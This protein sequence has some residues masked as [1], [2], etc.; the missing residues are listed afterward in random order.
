MALAKILEDNGVIV[1]YNSKNGK[2]YPALNKTLL[3]EAIQK[4]S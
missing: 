2:D 4:L 3:K 1:K